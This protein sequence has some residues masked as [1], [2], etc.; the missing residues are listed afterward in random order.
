MNTLGLYDVKCDNTRVTNKLVEWFFFI[1]FIF[2]LFFSRW[3]VLTLN[4][5]LQGKRRWPMCPVLAAHAGTPS[6]WL[7]LTQGSAP[8]T[9][10]HPIVGRGESMAR[11][12]TGS[13]PF[14][15]LPPLPLLSPHLFLPPPR[16]P[17]FVCLK[18]LRGVRRSL[19]CQVLLLSITEDA[20]W[21]SQAGPWGR[22]L[23]LLIIE[24]F[25]KKALKV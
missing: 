2:W 9:H 17:P 19:V 24:F 22:T 18:E 21:Q 20:A 12:I 25:L 14:A 11:T 23:L 15:P 1:P 4:T 7:P 8:S 10:P 3:M 13:R 16:P 5:T 6:P